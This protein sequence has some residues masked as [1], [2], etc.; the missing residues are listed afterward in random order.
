MSSSSGARLETQWYIKKSDL[1]EAPPVT[2]LTSEKT[3]FAKA[4]ERTT[5]DALEKMKSELEVL[6]QITDVALLVLAQ[7]Y[8]RGLHPSITRLSLRT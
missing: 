3:P 5:K 2:A 4:T 8:I 1:I 7:V 6:D